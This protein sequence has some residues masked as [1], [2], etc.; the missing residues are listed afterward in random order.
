MPLRR[1]TLLLVSLATILM[2]AVSPGAAETME[3]TAP[4]VVTMD[5][6]K[7]M[8]I[9]APAATIIIGNPSIAD[10]T[11]QDSQT[12][13]ITGRSYGVTNVIILDSEGEPI[14]DTQVQVQAPTFNLVTVQKGGSR[15]SMSCLDRCEPT[16]VPGDD[17]E[18]YT[19]IQNQNALRNGTAG[20]N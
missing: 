5:Q 12:L 3:P 7:V 20:G 9:S 10:A 4:V 18:F 19:N 16:L 13:V 14:A 8:R 17:T 15:Y 11:M 2:A 6:A 1:A